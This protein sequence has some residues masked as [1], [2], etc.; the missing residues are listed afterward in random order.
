[1][2]L[3]AVE[4]LLIVLIFYIVTTQVILPIAKGLPVFPMFRKSE[5]LL[6]DKLVEVNQEVHEQEISKEIKRKQQSIKGKNKNVK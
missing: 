4:G 6:K 5:T 1:M 2:W 3:I